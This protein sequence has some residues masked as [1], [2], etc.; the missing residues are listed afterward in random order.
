MIRIFPC[1]TALAIGLLAGHAS[2]A[3]NAQKPAPLPSGATACHFEALT[4]DPDPNG[5]N[6]RRAPS[7]IVPILGRLPPVQSQE[8]AI[9]QILPQFHVIGT[10]KDW[11]LIEGATYDSGYDPPANAPK[12]Y[13]GRG[14][15]AGNHIATGL[16]APS[17]KQ[18]PDA[19][20]ADVVQLHGTTSD[21]GGFGPDSISV[22]QILDCTADWFEVRSNRMTDWRQKAVASSRSAAGPT[23][24]APPS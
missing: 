2:V 23:N 20:A 22:R 7:A 10:S 13:A 24:T 15:V 5:V 1:G 17:L 4:H 8:A 6:I 12:L 11:F 14:W 3:Q 18:K 16:R 19:G 21:G 9:G